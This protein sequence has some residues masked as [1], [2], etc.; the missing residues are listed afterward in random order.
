MLAQGN[1]HVGDDE[2][3]V[4]LVVDGGL[5]KGTTE[6]LHHAQTRVKTQFISLSSLLLSSH[7]NP[8]THAP[9][10]HH[11]CSSHHRP[12]CLCRR[13]RIRRS[14]A[15]RGDLVEGGHDGV[16]GGVHSLTVEVSAGLPGDEDGGLPD[17]GENI[18][19]A[20]R[21]GSSLSAHRTQWYH[22]LLSG[23]PLVHA[24]AACRLCMHAHKAD[25]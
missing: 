5:V 17:E 12:S 6:R 15:D 7:P 23:L 2:E 8:T 3:L 19:E 20:L 21:T 4:L 13:A 16:A 10:I 25:L 18:L 11:T 1:L 9:H 22:A 14:E 24:R